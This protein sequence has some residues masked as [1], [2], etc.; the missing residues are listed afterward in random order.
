[1]N[2]AAPLRLP[3]AVRDADAPPNSASAALCAASAMSAALALIVL[4]RL[5][6]FDRQPA[7]PACRAASHGHARMYASCA[8]VPS[9]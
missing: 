7:E 5:R 9:V 4:Q 2:A 1:M 3:P 6:R 8:Y